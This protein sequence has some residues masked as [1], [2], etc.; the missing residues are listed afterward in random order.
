MQGVQPH[1][2]AKHFGQ[3]WLDFVKFG[4]IWAKLRRNLGKLKRNLSKFD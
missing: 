1:P 2:A 4:S 3:N